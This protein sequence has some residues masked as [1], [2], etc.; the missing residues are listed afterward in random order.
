VS[1]FFALEQLSKTASAATLTESFNG[2][3]PILERLLAEMRQHLQ[4]PATPA[5]VG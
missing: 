1:D 4:G 5:A 2:L 3:R